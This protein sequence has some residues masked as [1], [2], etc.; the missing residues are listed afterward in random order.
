VCLL[1]PVCVVYFDSHVGG[2]VCGG[3]CLFGS[4]WVVMCFGSVF[5]VLLV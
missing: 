5:F 2:S 4:W 1:L 3:C